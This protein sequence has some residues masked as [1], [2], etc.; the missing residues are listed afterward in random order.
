MVR[1]LPLNILPWNLFRGQLYVIRWQ[2]RCF[3]RKK[4]YWKT[5]LKDTFSPC[6]MVLKPF[7]NRHLNLTH[8]RRPKM[9]HLKLIF[10]VKQP[11]RVPLTNYFSF[12]SF[13]YRFRWS[14]SDASLV[15]KIR[16]N[17][18]KGEGLSVYEVR[19]VKKSGDTLWLQ[20]RIELIEYNGKASTLGYFSYSAFIA[21]LTNTHFHKMLNKFNS[22]LS[23]W[24]W[25][26]W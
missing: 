3:T 6:K 26:Q 4:I 10:L 23:G 17:R 21:K 5:G 20:R 22:I 8:H 9:T 1:I 11:H 15:E 14:H 12:S 24:S 19:G 25:S 7:V 13:H 16:R 2:K 18:L